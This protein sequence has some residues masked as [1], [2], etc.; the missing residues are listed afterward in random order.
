VT[1]WSGEDYAKVSS[2]QRTMAGMV[3]G[4]YAVGADASKRMIATADA[5]GAP[6]EFGPWFGFA[7]ARR[8]PF[9]EHFDVVVSFNALHWV[10]EQRQAL[11]QIATV[12]RPGRRSYSGGL[13]G[14]ADQS[15]SGGDGDLPKPA[16]GSLVRRVHRAL[17]PRG[18]GRLRRTG[19]IGGIDGHQMRA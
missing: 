9:G 13:C 3:P 6:A 8:L 15:G 11:G 5:A 4:G 7:D 12:L 16:L 19:G 14:G 1:D 2:L 18:S 17:H 10:P